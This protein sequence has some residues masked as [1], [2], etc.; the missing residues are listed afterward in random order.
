MENDRYSIIK[1]IDN[2]K[3]GEIGI[4]IAS[5]LYIYIV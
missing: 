2:F 5:Y 4:I 3:T 1:K